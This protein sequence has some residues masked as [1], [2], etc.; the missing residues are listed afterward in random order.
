MSAQGLIVAIIVLGCCAYAAWTLM[1]SAARRALAAALMKLPLPNLCLQHLA[2][3]AKPSNSCGC[4][5]CD[6]SELAPKLGSQPASKPAVVT[7]HPR[8]RR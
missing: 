8:L 7:F 3:A 6:R 1:P 4:D 5:G 2:R